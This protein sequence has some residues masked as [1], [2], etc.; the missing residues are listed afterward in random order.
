MA[1]RGQLR[2]R[3][4]QQSALLID[5]LLQSPNIASKPINVSTE[6]LLGADVAIVVLSRPVQTANSQQKT[7]IS[8]TRA[9]ESDAV[10]ARNGPI[11]PDLALIIEMWPTLSE[12]SKAEVITIVKAAE[13][14]PR[15]P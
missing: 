14:S 15:M 7:A 8:E 4:L 9:A 11:D 1:G 13:Q 5:I 10:A 2:T 12:A 3:A 6:F